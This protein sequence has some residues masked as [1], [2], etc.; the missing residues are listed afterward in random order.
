[1]KSGL[2]IFL[3]IVI[4]GFN[5]DEHEY[6]V[7]VNQVEYNPDT[8]RFE[9]GIKVF[10]DDFEAAIKK[11]SGENLLLSDKSAR[12]KIDEFCINYLE[13][14]LVFIRKN[15]MLKQTF[16]GYE[17]GPDETWL[18]LE[19]KAAPV[20]KYQIKNTILFDIYQDQINIMHLK[21]EEQS[22]SFYF[23]IS[24]PLIDLEL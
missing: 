8:D 13:N 20:G 22:H 4:F 17:A 12:K 7:S 3:F 10:T 14:N 1:M 24:K 6:Y 21:A 19:I 23:S 9:I 18:Y 16:I 2:F 15:K 5:T 11:G